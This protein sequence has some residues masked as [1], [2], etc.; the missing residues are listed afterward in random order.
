MRCLALRVLVAWLNQNRTSPASGLCPLP[1]C[2]VAWCLCERYWSCSSKADSWTTETRTLSLSA[3]ASPRPLYDIFGLTR[4]NSSRSNPSLHSGTLYRLRKCKSNLSFS[5][6]WDGS[7]FWGFTVLGFCTSCLG[8]RV[9][10]PRFR[11]CVCLWL[12]AR[13]R[14]CLRRLCLRRRIWWGL[15]LGFQV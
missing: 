4:T 3:V 7:E 11:V 12:C 9:L 15:R 8:T 14:K 2:S 1:K 5:G 10:L 6:C 13:Y